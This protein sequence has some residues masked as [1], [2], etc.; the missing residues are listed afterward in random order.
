MIHDG[1][2]NYTH[3]TAKQF[4]SLVFSFA[5]APRGGPPSFF[6]PTRRNYP[7]E[8]I[9]KNAI[10]PFSPSPSS[11]SLFFFSTRIPNANTRP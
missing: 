9:A 11:R 2:A 5:H 10:F 7:R 8:K 1:P 3:G 6:A 4:L